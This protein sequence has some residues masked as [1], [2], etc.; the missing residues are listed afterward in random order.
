MQAAA[1]QQSLSLAAWVR[2]TLREA[3]RQTPTGSVERKL[4]SVR[5]AV[6]HSFPSADIERMLEEI[7]RGYGVGS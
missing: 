1:K 3:L 7:E 2:G 6:R 4:E 5:A